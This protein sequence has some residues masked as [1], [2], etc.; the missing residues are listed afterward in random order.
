MPNQKDVE[1]PK[2]LCYIA[3]LVCFALSFTSFQLGELLKLIPEFENIKVFA[4]IFFLFSYTCYVS[5]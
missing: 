2:C 4:E 5:I 3:L 1:Y